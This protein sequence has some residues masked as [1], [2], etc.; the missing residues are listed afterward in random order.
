MP[1]QVRS[2]NNYLFFFVVIGLLCFWFQAEQVYAAPLIYSATTTIPLASPST[3]LAI[4]AGSVADSFQVNATSVMVTLSSSTGGSFTLTSAS[5][6]LA[7]S[8]SSAGGSAVVSCAAGIETAVLSQNTGSSVYMVTPTT[9][10]CAN[11]F[12]PVITDIAASGVTTNSATVSW[13]TNVP[14]TTTIEYGTSVSYGSSVDDANLTTGDSVTLSGLSAD[15]TYHFAIIASADV[16]STTSGD[17]TFTTSAVSSGGGGSSGVSVSVPSQYG[18]PF[19]PSVGAVATETPITT[20]ATGPSSTVSGT[21]TA[22]LE[23]ELQSLL[24]EL[25]VLEAQ[26]QTQGTAATASPGT[27]PLSSGPLSTSACPVLP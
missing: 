20:S 26:S 24:A 13:T 23:A 12:P 5:Y 25:A 27:L 22:A 19:T 4:L 7:V 10:N 9:S 21:S 3:T 16:T 1:Q 6:D 18:Q 17:A 15:M 8:S 2:V 14:A 11:A